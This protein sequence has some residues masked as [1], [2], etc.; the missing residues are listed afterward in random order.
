MADSDADVAD[1]RRAAA[2]GLAP[3]PSGRPNSLTSSA[4][5]T[6]NRSVIV[7]FIEALSS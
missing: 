3:P 5:A 1:P 6:L 4:P 7:A 2:E